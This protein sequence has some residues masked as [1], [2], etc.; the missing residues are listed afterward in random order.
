MTDGAESGI[1]RLALTLNY[2]LAEVV[3]DKRYQIPHEE[4]QLI[5]R[6]AEIHMQTRGSPLTRVAE[7]EI[8]DIAQKLHARRQRGVLGSQG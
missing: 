1:W 3:N 4:R 8:E 7:A 2:I 5:M 6:L